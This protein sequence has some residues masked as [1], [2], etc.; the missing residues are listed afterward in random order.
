MNS[1][2]RRGQT[3]K[4]VWIAGEKNQQVLIIDCE[5]TDSKSRSEEDRGKFEHSS[6]LFALAMSDVLIVNMW[7]SDVGRYTA[8]N[9]GV[10]KIVFEMNLK[11]FQQECAKKILIMLRDFDPKRNAREKIESMILSDIHKIWEEI[12]KPEKFKDSTPEKFFRFEF[13][14]LSHKVYLPEKF[15]S[16]VF[17]LRQRLN[18]THE[19]Y[20]FD[21]LSNQKGVPADGLKQYITQLWNDIL[22]EK[23]LNI[24]SQK[25]MLA[26]YRCSEIKQNILNAHDAEF[27]EFTNLTS[28]KGDD[29]FIE[30]CKSIHDK[31]VEEYDKTASNYETKIYQNIRKQ[32]EEA[33]YQ[34]CYVCF[35]NQIKLLIPYIQKFMRSSLKNALKKGKIYN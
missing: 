25:E 14:T 26:N 6:S 13:I 4:G 23:E 15:N 27:K 24:P 7:T 30:K 31:M 28:S 21:H 2:V 18:S 29:S 19:N 10:L 17:E 9:Y 35:L 22:N 32:L 5:G 12:K 11:L 1:S 16:E 3:T 20:I 8:S 34:R 33:I